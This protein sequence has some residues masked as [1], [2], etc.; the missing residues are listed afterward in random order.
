MELVKW[1]EIELADRCFVSGQFNLVSHKAFKSIS[2]NPAV[3]LA[4]IV[5]TFSL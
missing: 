3:N 4:K 1:Y 2:L 5:S